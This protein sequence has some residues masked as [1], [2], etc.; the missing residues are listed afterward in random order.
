MGNESSSDRS[1]AVDVTLYLNDTRNVPLEADERLF[2]WVQQRNHENVLLTQDTPATLRV[3]QSSVLRIGVW[4]QKRGEDDEPIAHGNVHIPIEAMMEKSGAALY[5]TWFLLEPSG[6]PMRDLKEMFDYSLFE[7]ARKVFVPKICITLIRREEELRDGLFCPAQSERTKADRYAP[8]LLSHLQH[9]QLCQTLT[10]SLESPEIRGDKHKEK[11]KMLKQQ[12]KLLKA[13]NEKLMQL[14]DDLQKRHRVSTEQQNQQHR[15][16]QGQISRMQDNHE[17]MSDLSSSRRSQEIVEQITIQ[18]NQRIDKAND[19]INQLRSR[20]L[21]EA[22]KQQAD[23]REHETEM[24]VLREQKIALMKIV[25]DLYTQSSER[26]AFQQ[27]MLAAQNVAQP[28]GSYVL[29]KQD[30]M[31]PNPG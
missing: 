25:E 28:N 10:V 12:I 20:L 26:S 15:Q 18:A 2:A 14:M 27:S 13:E 31:S 6:E 29:P 3:S 22:D 19:T 17:V 8:L 9:L 16:L 24:K 23:A 11:N 1:Y 30:V 7:V 21:E 4:T 5:H